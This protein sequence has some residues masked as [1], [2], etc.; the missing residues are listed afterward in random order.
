MSPTR[1]LLL[2]RRNC[3]LCAEAEQV[4]AEV[5][6]QARATV[7][8]VDVDNDEMLRSTFNDHVPV[9]FVDGRLHGYWFV[10]ASKLAD[11]LAAEARPMPNDWVPPR[12]S[13]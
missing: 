13:A 8:V 7:R 3:T 10:D 11:A 6:G 2:T 9:T 4:V 1:V 5:C 12:I